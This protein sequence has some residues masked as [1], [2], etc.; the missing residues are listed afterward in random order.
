MKNLMQTLLAILLVIATAA[1]TFAQT[2]SACL[3]VGDGF[4]I[5]RSESGMY[6]IGFG[7]D[8]QLYSPDDSDEITVQVVVLAQGGGSPSIYEATMVS[9]TYDLFSFQLGVLAP[10]LYEAIVGFTDIDEVCTL[11]GGLARI[12]IKV[13]HDMECVPT[14]TNTDAQINIGACTDGTA[15]INLV[16]NSDCQLD[17]HQAIVYQMFSGANMTPIDTLDLTGFTVLDTTLTY[18][19]YADGGFVYYTARVSRVD[20]SSQPIAFAWASAPAC[21]IPEEG[22]M[23]CV[24]E[25][26]SV[27]NIEVI[28]CV[29]ETKAIRVSLSGPSSCNTQDVALAILGSGVH[30][31]PFVNVNNISFDP[32]GQW[33][34]EFD[35]SINR[36]GAY[37]ARLFIDNVIVASEVV[38]IPPCPDGNRVA[39]DDGIEID[40]FPN[41]ASDYLN[42]ALDESLAEDSNVQIIDMQ[43]RL[44]KSFDSD[45]GLID[46]SV[47]EIPVGMYLLKVQIEGGRT[48]T[49]KIVIQR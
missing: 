27:E 25:N 6:S 36:E 19:S 18:P 28:S 35:V 3:I 7:V 49:G 14:Q 1:S 41:P 10:G 48:A 11:G 22:G 26:I 15:D 4:A 40:V 17:G 12:P 44:V 47:S 42:V 46:L 43:G 2:N 8:A 21:S 16:I 5:S 31:T 9:G 24:A 45:N 20:E 23:E 13:L 39:G 29:G 38:N 32:N 30:P 34:A 33:Y 37:N